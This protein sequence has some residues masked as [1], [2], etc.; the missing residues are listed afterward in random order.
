MGWLSQGGEGKS[1]EEISMEYNL[2]Y[3]KWEKGKIL[4]KKVDEKRGTG[5]TGGPGKGSAKSLPVDE[6]SRVGVGGTRKRKKETRGGRRSPRNMEEIGRTE[7]RDSCIVRKVHGRHG[8]QA[9]P[10]EKCYWGTSVTVYM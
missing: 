9:G 2:C 3:H 6:S 5:A 7:P 8:D 4:K 10:L 1:S